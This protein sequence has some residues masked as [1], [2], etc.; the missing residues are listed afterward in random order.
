MVREA[1]VSSYDVETWAFFRYL[2]GACK[3]G[4]ERFAVSQSAFVN[5]SSKRFHY[6]QLYL[7]GYAHI[8][9]DS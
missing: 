4:I 5:C 3:G 6:I 9:R 7:Y 2:S 1:L 8:K